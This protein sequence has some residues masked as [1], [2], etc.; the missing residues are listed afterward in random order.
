MFL[1]VWSFVAQCHGIQ[2][3]DARTG[4]RKIAASF[5]SHRTGNLFV[6]LIKPSLTLLLVINHLL[7][8][9]ISHCLRNADRVLTGNLESMLGN[10][11]HRPAWASQ[12]WS[13]VNNIALDPQESA[14]NKKFNKKFDWQ[15]CFQLRKH[16]NT[17]E[18]VICVNKRMRKRWKLFIGL[19]EL[20]TFDENK[21]NF[22]DRF[23][24][25]AMKSEICHQ[26]FDAASVEH[27][28]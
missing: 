18:Y 7:T 14:T 24:H 3:E 10:N 1:C 21:L 12:H 15:S 5:I 27:R 26:S 2:I 16:L 11:K 9:K 22:V 8:V 28:K 17:L 4:K 13:I 25:E 19:N 23:G 20:D 6:E